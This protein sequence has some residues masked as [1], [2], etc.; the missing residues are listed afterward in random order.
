MKS[1]LVDLILG[2]VKR[3]QG[4]TFDKVTVHS[5]TPSRQ[6][7]LVH[8]FVYCTTR[9]QASSFKALLPFDHLP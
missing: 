1:A 5:E 2:W 6:R 9:L 7:D 8:S 4:P 3:Q